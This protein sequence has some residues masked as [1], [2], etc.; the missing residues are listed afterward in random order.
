M[1]VISLW[2]IGSFF[3]LCRYVWMCTFWGGLIGFPSFFFFLVLDQ[4]KWKWKVDD[5]RSNGLIGSVIVVGRARNWARFQSFS[6]FPPVS[7]FRKSLLCCPAF[8]YLLFLISLHLMVSIGSILFIFFFIYYIKKIRSWFHFFSHVLCIFTKYP[9]P[10]QT[11]I[12]IHLVLITNQS[13][14]QVAYTNTCRFNSQQDNPFF[15]VL[16]QSN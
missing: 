15:V 6:S 5:E 14:F 10:K 7:L 13:I 11:N 16:G 3:S 1:S 4:Q 2:I 9:Q 12:C 8:V